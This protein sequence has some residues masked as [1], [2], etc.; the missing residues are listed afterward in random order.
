MNFDFYV[1]FWKRGFDFKGR[2]S[3]EEFW[4]TYLVNCLITLLLTFLLFVPFVAVLQS[5]WGLAVLIPTVAI[6]VRRLHDSNKSCIP[7]IVIYVVEMISMCIIVFSFITLII[8]AFSGR[9]L[10]AVGILGFFIPGLAFLVCGIVQIVYMCLPSTLGMNKYGPMREK[11][12]LKEQSQYKQ[13]EQQNINQ[14]IQT[15]QMHQNINNP[16]F[17]SYAKTYGQP[18]DV[19]YQNVNDNNVQNNEQNPV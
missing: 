3:R 8:L 13:N 1:D 16:Y 15:E 10:T 5:I 19:H 7:I 9:D 18:N 2:S 4:Y 6:S 11:L 17:Q 12:N 14:N